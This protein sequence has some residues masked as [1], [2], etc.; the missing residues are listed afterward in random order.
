MKRKTQHNLYIHLVW[1]T[2]GRQ[3][4]I[5]PACESQLYAALAYKCG[6]LNCVPTAI[7]GTADH[8]HLMVKILPA[9][10]ISDLVQKLKG[11]SSRKMNSEIAPS[12]EFQWQ[13]GYGVFSVGARQTS[14]VARYIRQQ[15]QRHA[16]TDLY[17][18]W[19]PPK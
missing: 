17:D 10:R 8:V 9:V 13:Q 15:K 6:V 11:F 18:E 4:L 2:Y 7:G 16:S 1:S 3:P 12:S 5:N 19:E 14:I